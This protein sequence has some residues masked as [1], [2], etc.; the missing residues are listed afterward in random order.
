MRELLL[1]L[2]LQRVIRTGAVRRLVTAAAEIREG[3]TTQFPGVRAYG[4]VSIRAARAG[5]DAGR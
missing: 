1:Q 3:I 4:V 5:T 2:G